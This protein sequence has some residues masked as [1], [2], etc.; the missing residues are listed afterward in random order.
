M[1]AYYKIQLKP[2]EHPESLW[3]RIET[4][5]KKLAELKV[6]MD[7]GAR[8][9]H[10]TKAVH[11]TREGSKYYQ[12]LRDYKLAVRQGKAPT[13]K[14]LRIALTFRYEELKRRA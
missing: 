14:D 5:A 13:L 11:D 10:F 8:E 12:Q 7:E 4:A 6:S 3:T 9:R 1:N 2:Q